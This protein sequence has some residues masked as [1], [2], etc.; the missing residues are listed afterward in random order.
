MVGDKRPTITQ[1]T[2]TT[3]DLAR[4]YIAVVTSELKDKYLANYPDIIVIGTLEGDIVGKILI[5]SD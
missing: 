5:L 3:F 1:L 2:K 4:V